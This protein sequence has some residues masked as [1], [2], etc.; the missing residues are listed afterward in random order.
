MKSSYF[1]KIA[2][3]AFICLF[4]L[5][6]IWLYYTYNQRLNE[7]EF[8]I[9]DCFYDA[10]DREL[11]KRFIMSNE[12]DPEDIPKPEVEFKFDSKKIET[13][14]LKSLQSDFM[15]Y[16]M[17]IN[18]LSFNLKELDS[19]YNSLLKEQNLQVNYQLIYI[20]SLNQVIATTENK[21]NGDFE[22]NIIPIV[23]GT[24]VQAIV[25]ISVPTVLRNMLGILVVSVLILFLIIG[26]MIYEAKIFRRQQRI[27]RLREDFSNALIHDMKTPLG[28]IYIALDHWQ[29]GSLD[30][31]PEKKEKF[32]EVAMEQVFN[33]QTLTDQV[34]TIAKA[35]Q[36]QLS[37]D[38]QTVDLPEM[39]QLLI[40]KFTLSGSKSMEFET[41]YNLKNAVVCA[42][43]LH[44]SRAVGNLIDNAIKYSGDTVHIAIEC[45]AG[46][47]QI[48]IK[49]K[50]NGFGISEKDQ[51]KIFEKFERGM[52]LKRNA[53]RG[54][55]IGLNYV[56]QV[57]VAHNG[58]IALS[59]I[60]KR[61]SEFV[62]AIPIKLTLIEEEIEETVI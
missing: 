61:G 7:I 55:G 14:G 2:A 56:K 22:T 16:L 60:E 25:D 29:T 59:S 4:V 19:I 48:F 36:N 21:V 58:T 52:E 5:Q 28:T 43:P 54:F 51:Q 10:T 17:D 37:L 13:N 41:N 8:S 23:N 32:C 49:V 9:N 11:D 47:K 30:H 42:D 20:D 53:I 35:E 39:I 40:K 46:E 62:I 45:I 50:D 12:Q 44:L 3:V 38:L 34:L 1:I 18:G 6:G 27:F 24:K 26:C 31:L 15:Q 57:A 33:L